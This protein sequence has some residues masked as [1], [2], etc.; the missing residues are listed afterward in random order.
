MGYKGYMRQGK[1]PQAAKIL[2]DSGYRATGTGGRRS[3][4]R[5]RRRKSDP[6]KLEIGA[7]LR[8]ETTLTIKASAA[9]VHLGTS[10]AANAN[11][12]RHLRQTAAASKGRAR[13]AGKRR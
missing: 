11:L 9:R 4:R 7:R 2:M 10:N 3:G 8:R 13:S 6:D 1:A 5:S 12:H